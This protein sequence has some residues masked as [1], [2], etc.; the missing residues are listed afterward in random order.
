MSDIALRELEK[1]I[2]RA[3][4]AIELGASLARLMSNRDFQS[5]VVS[6]FLQKEAIRLVHAKADPAN[7]SP[8]AQQGIVRSLDAI[9]NFNQ[10]LCNV[11]LQAAISEK[12]LG[13]AEDE[14]DVLLARG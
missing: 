8:E 1:D 2:Q 5:V 6:G 14:R 10:Y 7:Q 4:E 12:I 9:G 13:Q 3:R 11:S